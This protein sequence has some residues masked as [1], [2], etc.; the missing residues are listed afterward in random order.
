MLIRLASARDPDKDENPSECGQQ[1]VAE[2]VSWSP[3]RERKRHHE[4]FWGSAYYRLPGFYRRSVHSLALPLDLSW[5]L[6][7]WCMIA[8][9]AAGSASFSAFQT[10]SRCLISKGRDG[11]CV[12][13]ASQPSMRRK[14]AHG[15]QEKMRRTQRPE[16][17]RATTFCWGSFHIHKFAHTGSTIVTPMFPAHATI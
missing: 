9:W 2:A 1:R 12:A 15:L 10:P 7:P 6:E 4:Q 17:W 11:L 8:M 3:T 5:D 16:K 13:T 14:H